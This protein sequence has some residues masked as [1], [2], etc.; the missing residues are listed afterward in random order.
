MYALREF[1]E[2]YNAGHVINVKQVKAIQKAWHELE[3]SDWFK[4]QKPD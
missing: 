3:K 1:S 4:A 2:T